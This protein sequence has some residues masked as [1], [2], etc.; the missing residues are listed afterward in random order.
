MAPGD[1]SPAS[2][3]AAFSLISPQTAVYSSSLS[4]SEEGSPP[5]IRGP[6]K[7]V[8]KEIVLLNFCATF[9]QT[10][11]NFTSNKIENIIISEKD[12]NNVPMK[13]SGRYSTTPHFGSIGT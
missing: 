5:A 9:S 10:K 11:N 7:L 12:N 13:R 3:R 2:R 6:H 8:L 1:T 4:S